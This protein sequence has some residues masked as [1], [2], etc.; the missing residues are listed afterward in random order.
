MTRGA[1]AQLLLEEPATLQ[2]MSVHNLELCKS[3]HRGLVASQYVCNHGFI[4]HLHVS[5]V[6]V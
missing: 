1:F 2:K 4:I 6:R 5:R 3:S